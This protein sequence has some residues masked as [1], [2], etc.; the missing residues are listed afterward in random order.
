M[1]VKKFL[2]IVIIIIV[3][4]ILCVFGLFFLMIWD[5]ERQFR[6]HEIIG[7]LLNMLTYMV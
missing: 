2:E 4:L 7:N 5:D 3:V 1:K 6:N